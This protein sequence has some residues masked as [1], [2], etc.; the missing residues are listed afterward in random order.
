MTVKDTEATI[1]SGEPSAQQCLNQP[2][3]KIT[4]LIGL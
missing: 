4:Y 1:L 3:F 2:S